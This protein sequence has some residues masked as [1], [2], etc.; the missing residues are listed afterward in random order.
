MVSF[1]AWIYGYRRMFAI[2]NMATSKIATAAQG[3]VELFGKISSNPENWVTSPATGMACVWYRYLIEEKSGDDWRIVDSGESSLTFE[4][5]DATG[6]CTVDPEGAEL[7]ACDKTVKRESNRRITEYRLT[8]TVYVLGEFSTLGGEH[9]QLDARHDIAKLLSEWKRDQVQL[10]SR[11]DK[12]R[13]GEIDLQE[14]EDA[15]KAAALEVR[16]Q[17]AEIRQTTPVVHIMRKPKGN[18]PYILSAQNPETLH[19]MLRWQGVLH[20]VIA[21]AAGFAGLSIR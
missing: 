12:N 20:L 9:H 13:D 6:V 1:F 19:R 10:K 5:E 4:M 7:V 14:W 15:R 2:S 18:R 8:K 21:F 11:F 17:H 3:Y 16:K